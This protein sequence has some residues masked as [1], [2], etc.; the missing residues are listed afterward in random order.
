MQAD[1]LPSEPPGK[2]NH[3]PKLIKINKTDLRTPRNP[4]Q[5]GQKIK[6]KPH[7]LRHIIIKLLKS[8]DRKKETSKLE[9]YCV[10]AKLLQSCPTLCDPMD[11]SPPGFSVHGDSPGKNTGVGCHALLQGN[12]PDPGIEPMYPMAPALQADSL[13]LSHQGRIM[14]G[15]GWEK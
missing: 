10:H 1:T 4:K 15:Q 6:I 5:T 12:L 14:E 8:K 3:F 2:P 7:T 9:W 13:L 11:C